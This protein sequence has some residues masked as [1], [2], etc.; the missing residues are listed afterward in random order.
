MKIAKNRQKSRKVTKSAQNRPK[1]VVEAMFERFFGLTSFKWVQKLHF[2]TLFSTH[3]ILCPVRK[4]VP[5][6]FHLEF[7]EL[8][9]LCLP[10]KK[11]LTPMF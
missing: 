6:P 3:V 2:Y 10:P 11:L 1:W 5:P 9:T 7:S 8:S 4:R